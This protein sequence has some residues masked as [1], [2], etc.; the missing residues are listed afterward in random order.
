MRRREPIPPRVMQQQLWGYAEHLRPLL[1]R[2]SPRSLV[3]EGLGW[4]DALAFNE[5]YGRIE[6]RITERSG[7]RREADNRMSRG[8]KATTKAVR[9]GIMPHLFGRHLIDKAVFL[10]LNEVANNLPP[11]LEECIPVRMD[12]DELA[13]AYRREVEEPLVEAI[14]E[15]MKRRDRRLLGAMLQTLLAY[16]DYPF[17]WEPVGYWKDGLFVTVAKPPALAA[18]TVRPKERALIDLVRSERAQGRQ[19]W[20]YVQYTDRHDVQGRLERLLGE[21]GLR[22]GVLRSSVPLNR[23][24]NW[25]GKHAPH[26][27]VIISHPRLVETGLD[28]FDKC[29]RYN[30]PTICFYETGYNLFTLRQASRRSWRIGQKEACRVVYLYY[31]GTMQDRAVALMGKKLTAAQALE[32]K[33]SSEGLV[34]MAGEDANVEIALARSLVDRMDEGDSRRQW[35]RAMTGNDPRDHQFVQQGH[36]Q[37]LAIPIGQV[38]D[39]RREKS[40]LPVLA[41]CSILH[42]PMR[43]GDYHR[44]GRLPS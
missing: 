17:E 30:F 3:Q 20:V 5:R 1:F 27:D 9:P 32:G 21:H 34:A 41:S 25:I 28:L 14:R 6:T 31:Q 33:F 35:A 39:L 38:T 13:M 2:L 40:N 12:D 29:G 24:E 7:G 42:C 10:G 22:V 23:R 36:D 26:A 4:S 18:N 15:M 19:V 44:T 16:P 43:P 37:T 8:S 11:L